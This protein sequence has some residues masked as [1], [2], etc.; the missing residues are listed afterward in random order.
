MFSAFSLSVILTF[1]RF[2][3]AEAP[4]ILPAPSVT[5]AVD[6]HDVLSSAARG[7][8][9]AARGS[10]SAARGREGGG[11]AAAVPEPTT[12]LLVGG[13]LV[14]LALARRRRRS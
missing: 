9:S 11:G 3:P 6:G 4:P 2:G 13:G 8:S 7:S 1:V 5:C 10:S 12:L 14:G